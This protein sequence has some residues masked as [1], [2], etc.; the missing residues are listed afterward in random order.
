MR[1][2]IYSGRGRSDLAVQNDVLIE[3][4]LPSIMSLIGFDQVTIDESWDWVVSSPE[5]GEL[6]GMS[7]LHENRIDD[8]A[9]LYLTEKSDAARPPIVYDLRPEFR[10]IDSLPRVWRGDDRTLSVNVIAALAFAVIVGAVIVRAPLTVSTWTALTAVGFAVALLGWL[11]RNQHGLPIAA[12]GTFAAAA[13][14]GIGVDTRIHSSTVGWLTAAV[15][16][17]FLATAATPFNRLFSSSIR[18]AVLYVGIVLAGAGLA[19][20][21]GASPRAIAAWSVVPLVFALSS[22][23]RIGLAFS[24]LVDLVRRADEGESP[25]RTECE[26]ATDRGLLALNVTVFGT[27][28][29]LTVAGC[30]LAASSYLSQVALAGVLAA[31]LLLRTRSFTFAY[32][33]GAVFTAGLA[34]LFASVCGVARHLITD[35]TL[36]AF[37]CIG[38]PFFVALGMAYRASSEVSRARAARTLSLLDTVFMLSVVPMVFYAQGVYTYFWP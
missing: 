2:S 12:A 31:V 17:C 20:A 5:T 14:V 29:L 36:A 10:P 3:D 1:L 27:S 11:V 26:R 28:T 15:T 30:T 18:G 9:I 33:V 24:G 16:I 8:G 34:V 38:S 19:I 25:P 21:A 4:I 35:P 37:I 23:D 6:P 13:G 32:Q 7:T 22:A